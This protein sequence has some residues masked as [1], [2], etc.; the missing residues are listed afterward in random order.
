M[1]TKIPKELYVV[2][3]SPR[4]PVNPPLGFLNAYEPGKVTF[5]K[6]RKT[7]EEWAYGPYR[8]SRLVMQGGIYVLEYDEILSI[9]YSKVYNDPTRYTTQKTQVDIKSQPEIWKNDALTGFRILNFISRYSTS[10]KVWRILDPRGVEFEI[11]TS[12]LDE[13]IQSHGIKKG[14]EIDAKCCWAGNKNLVIV[15]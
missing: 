6:K 9:D 10:N 7:Q 15:G 8:N 11:P 4:D 13:I 1:A 2:L 3:K 5:E 12:K 14:G